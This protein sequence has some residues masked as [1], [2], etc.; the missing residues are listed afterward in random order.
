M[1]RMKRTPAV[2]RH[3]PPPAAA[4][5]RS[6]VWSG[7]PASAGDLRSAAPPTPALSPPSPAPPERLNEDNTA[8]RPLVTMIPDSY[9][10]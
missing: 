4:A 9:A 6:Y 3:R 10:C 8:E 2:Q 1:R 7:R 5:G